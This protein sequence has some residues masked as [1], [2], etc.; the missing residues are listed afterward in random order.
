ETGE[1]DLL[2]LAEAVVI[3]IAAEHFE[4]A[5]AGAEPTV[6]QGQR[7]RQIVIERV[8]ALLPLQRQREGRIGVDVDRVDRVHLNRDG[9]THAASSLAL[10]P[11]SRYTRRRPR[12]LPSRPRCD[13]E[14][15][16]PGR[17]ATLKGEMP[18]LAAV[19]GEAVALHGR[20][21]KRAVSACYGG[22]AG[23]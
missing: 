3:A 16:T 8:A 22:D 9:E 5:T 23:S 14:I 6:A 1:I 12:P 10:A 11:C 4:G 7:L 20:E 13:R 2:E 15:E 19:I 21:E 17:M 18:P